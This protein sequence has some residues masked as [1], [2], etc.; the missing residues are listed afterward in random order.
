V[1]KR[2]NQIKDMIIFRHLLTEFSL[3]MRRLEFRCLHCA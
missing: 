3:I 2:R 1:L